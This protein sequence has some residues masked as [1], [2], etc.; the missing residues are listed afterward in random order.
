MEREGWWDRMS[1]PSSTMETRCP[2]PMLGYRTM[3]SFMLEKTVNVKFCGDAVLGEILLYLRTMRHAYVA[4][5]HLL[6]F[7]IHIFLFIH[8]RSQLNF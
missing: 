4:L 3:V 5:S 1:L 2:L 6:F 7:F 8:M